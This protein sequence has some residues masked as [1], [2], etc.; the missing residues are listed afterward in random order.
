MKHPRIRVAYF[1]SRLIQHF[2]EKYNP[3][4]YA[5]PFIH[6]SLSQGVSGNE[7]IQ[8]PINQINETNVS[9]EVEPEPKLPDHATKRIPFICSKS[10]P[11]TNAPTPFNHQNPLQ[12]YFFH[13]IY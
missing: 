11:R 9:N 3:N 1:S 13:L 10:Y 2:N 12:S 7:A 8:K 5:N 4:M 6:P